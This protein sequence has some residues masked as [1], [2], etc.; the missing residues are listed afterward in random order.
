LHLDARPAADLPEYRGAEDAWRTTCSLDAD[1]PDWA[2]QAW[3]WRLLL[4]R[5]RID[6]LLAANNGEPTPE[7]SIALDEIAAIYHTDPVRSTGA[8]SPMTEE[9]LK[10]HRPQ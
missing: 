1:L 7:V 8:V 9:W 3:R 10:N 6:A 2:R 4:L 5:A